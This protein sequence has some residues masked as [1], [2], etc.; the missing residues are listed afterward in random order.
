MAKNNINEY[1]ATASNNEDVAGISVLGSAL[2]STIDNAHR[3]LMS[4]IADA[5][6][7]NVPVLDTWSW[8]DTADATKIG[9]FDMGGITTST[10]RVYTMPDASGTVVLANATQTLTGK[11]ISGGAIFDTTEF[12]HNSDNTK[13][14]LLQLSGITT[15]TTRTITIPDQNGTLFYKD[16][17]TNLTVGYTATSHNIGTVTSGTTTPDPANGNLQ[18]MVNGGASTLAA[19][20]A[21]GDYTMILQVTNNGSA[22]TLTLSGFTV[23]NGDALTTTD[24]DDFLLYITKVNGFVALQTV[25]LQ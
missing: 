16:A 17:S 24:G 15:S 21:T 13:K 23:T 20:T 5:V 18:R 1:D 7:G 4:H 2:P 22:G 10:T 25:A 11:T 6:Q 19:P 14:L 12:Q 9:R 3:A 8:R